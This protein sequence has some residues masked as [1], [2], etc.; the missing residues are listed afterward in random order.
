M[1]TVMHCVCPCDT[2]HSGSPM[3]L[4]LQHTRLCKFFL[5]LSLTPTHPRTHTHTHTHTR[6][7]SASL[8]HIMSWG[9]INTWLRVYFFCQ[10]KMH[11]CYLWNLAI[12]FWFFLFCFVLFFTRH[13][14]RE[15][16]RKNNNCRRQSLPA[17]KWEEKL[18]S[19][20]L[21]Y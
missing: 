6:K 15:K 13:I 18:H 20:F 2:F 11:G 8:F 1:S 9:G 5:S 17:Q 4:L 21:C 19:F 14:T 10:K 12:R 7:S 3:T 16:R